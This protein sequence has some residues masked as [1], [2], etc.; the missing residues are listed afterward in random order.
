MTSGDSPVATSGNGEVVIRGVAFAGANEPLEIV[1]KGNRITNI[2]PADGPVGWVCLPPLVDKHVHANR[3]FSLGGVKP[4]SFE[5]SI[6]LVME[7]LENFTVADYCRHAG[8][9]FGR[10]RSHA[11]TALRTH[12]DL[13]GVTRLQAV[14]GTLDA[15]AALG[16]TMD[17]EV[18]AFA[19]PRLDPSTADG[20][21]LL[22]E[23]LAAGADLIGAVPAFYPQP[24]RA[25]DALMELAGEYDVAVDV[26]QDEHL[27]PDKV[28]CERLADAVIG[29]GRQGKLS[30]S[31]GCALSV[32]EAT[33]R[34][35]IIE[36]LLQ[37]R[38]EVIVLP[39][40]NLYLQDRQRGTPLRRGLTCVHEMLD[41]G[42]EVRIATDNVCDAFY[43]YGDADLLDTLYVGML[44]AQVDAT[45]ALVKAICD[46]RAALSAGDAADL[47]LIKGTSFDDVLSRR[48]AERLIIRYG[49]PV[50]PGQDRRP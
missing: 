6:A 8:K 7:L 36:K 28:S 21:A 38:I 39:T 14:Q 13:D 20:K 12:A 16:D 35:R 30:L 43:P 37:A 10:A 29:A 50:D 31:H 2:N 1:V 32:L 44:G 49:T 47:V 33:A 18:V 9:L 17:I 42:I 48:P 41:A 22:R 4:T 46:G 45:T 19:S 5:H 34:N 3:A 26:H 25:I 15:K 11:T 24:T 40:T 27:S 23:A